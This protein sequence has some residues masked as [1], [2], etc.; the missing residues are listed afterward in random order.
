MSVYRLGKVPLGKCDI[1]TGYK[2]P[3][4]RLDPRTLAV[5]INSGTSVLLHTIDYLES[6]P[7]LYPSQSNLNV[8][9]D[10]VNKK[11]TIEFYLDNDLEETSPMV[12]YDDDESFWS[13]NCWG[14]G[15]KFW[16][17][18]EDTSN[19]IKGTSCVGML[20][21]AG[22]NN[23]ARLYHD[24][25]SNQDWSAYDFICLYVLDVNSGH[26]MALELQCPD[27]ANR[28]RPTWVDNWSG[29]KRLVLPLRKAWPTN[30]G[31]PNLAQ[32]RYADLVDLTQYFFDAGVRFDRLVLDVGQWVKT[33]LHIP[34]A[35]L[36]GLDVGNTIVRVWSYDGSYLCCTEGGENDVHARYIQEVTGGG[37]NAFRLLASGYNLGNVYA[38]VNRYDQKG[39]SITKQGKRGESPGVIWVSGPGYSQGLTYSSQPGMYLRWGF[40]LKMPP[41]DGQDS[42]TAGISQSRIK[43]EVNYV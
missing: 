16:T 19:Q 40:S 15:T 38:S 21:G 24:W 4:S 12:L 33:E 22:G 10:F 17:V 7:I 27:G 28:I 5:L 6:G 39:S 9:R 32:I 3:L 30:V 26:T 29:W 36:L 42:S 23:A 35:M 18:L 41:D 37:G 34:E 20:E 1:R 31:S 43:L 11:L 25:G 13:A 14:S 8:A 2:L